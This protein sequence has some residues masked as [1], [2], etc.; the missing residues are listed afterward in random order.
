MAESYTRSL[1]SGKLYF[2]DEGCTLVA[3]T[4]DG[5][6][7]VYTSQRLGISNVFSDGLSFRPYGRLNM[8]DAV[9]GGPREKE[10]DPCRSVYARRLVGCPYV[11]AIHSLRFNYET[12]RL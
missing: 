7:P 10:W 6:R 8:I 1:V 4:I 3:L 11:W 9:L 2:F 5:G 12:V